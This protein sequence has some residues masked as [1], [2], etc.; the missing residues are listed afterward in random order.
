MLNMSSTVPLCRALSKLGYAS[1]TQ[2][3]ALITDGEISV[4]GVTCRNP[5]QL[6]SLTTSKISRGGQQIACEELRVVLFYKPKGCITS[7]KDEL[8]RDTVYSFLPSQLHALHCVGRLD[9]ATS[10]LLLL[11]NNT[12]LS[13]W[14]TNPKNGVPRVY[15]VT[16]R[17]TMTD[18]K[19]QLMMKGVYDCGQE[20]RTDA[21]IVRKSSRK[22]TH[23]VIT[24]SEGKNREVRRLCSSVGN[25]V[26]R[27]KRVSYGPFTLGTLEPGTYRTVSRE[28]LL[29]AFPGVTLE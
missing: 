18:Q 5:Q 25:E 24:L 12:L 15:V 3:I 22:E 23:L 4:D 13:E 7:R 6:V 27:L 26:T 16:V 9:W 1:R 8:G 10:G 28:E 11:T 20:L 14:L 29:R 19:V 17:G 2:A 21:V